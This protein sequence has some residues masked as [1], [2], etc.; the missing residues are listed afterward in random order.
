MPTAFEVKIYK[1]WGGRSSAGNWV[2]SYV[3]GSE[4]LLVD[5]EIE[6]AVDALVSMEKQFHLTD[7][8]FMRAVISTLAKE[9]GYNP[10][11]VKSVEL[12]GQGIRAHGAPEGDP[13]ALDICLGVKL[14]GLTGRGG[15]MLYRGV[16]FE[17][18]VT[19]GERGRFALVGNVSGQQA[20]FDAFMAAGHDFNLLLANRKTGQQ[21]TVR[22][23]TAMSINNV[24]IKKSDVQRRKKVPTTTGG[25]V[26][27]LSNLLPLAA[28]IA[29]A[30]LTKNPAAF[31]AVERVG[32]I[33]H[34]SSLGALADQIIEHLPELP[35]P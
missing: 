17:A 3:I 27:S 15:L 28:G 26:G 19:K 24:V 33:G 13:L 5:S 8:H 21:D 14:N 10:A 20:N 30:I 9:G 35:G 11:N 18:D 32:I 34:A 12:S 1:A 31:S 6:L 29:A 16:L 22:P 7:V 2:N 4:F 23:V 25:I